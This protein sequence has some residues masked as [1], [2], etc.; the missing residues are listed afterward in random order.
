MA[1]TKMKMKKD[2]AKQVEAKGDLAGMAF[3][4]L[5]SILVLLQGGFYAEPSCIAGIAIVVM[6]IIVYVIQ[7]RRCIVLHVP[8]SAY[9]FLGIA[10]SALIGSSIAGLNAGFV[11]ETSPWFFAAAAATLSAFIR[12]EARESA[13]NMLGWVGVASA[14]V[15]IIMYA[16]LLPLE[17]SENMGRLQF[18]FQYANAAGIWFAIVSIVAMTSTEKR[19]R[20][21]GFFPLAALLFTQSVGAVSIFVIAIVLVLIRWGKEGSA[22]R[23]WALLMQLLCAFAACAIQIV[24]ITDLMFSPLSVLAGFGVLLLLRRLVG[25]ALEERPVSSGV[26]LA[27]SL[28]ILAIAVIACVGALAYTGRLLQ[29]SQTFIE[30]L[31]QTQDAIELLKEG[32]LFGTG[33]GSWS[34]LYQGVQSVQYTASVVHNS[35]AQ[36]ALDSGIVGL[37]LFLAIVIEGFILLRKKHD[38]RAM[39]LAVMMLLHFL[40]DFDLQ[41]TSLIMLFVLFIVPSREEEDQSSFTDRLS[42]LSL[43]AISVLCALGCAAGLWAQMQKNELFAQA[44]AGDLQLVEQ[45]LESDN[46]L[47][48]DPEMKELYLQCL[49]GQGEYSKAA[50]IYSSWDHTSANEATSVAYALYQADSPLEAEEILVE[51]LFQQPKNVDFFN[52]VVEIFAMQGTSSEAVERYAA[53]ATVA[54]QPAQGLGSLMTNQ[55]KVP[56]TLDEAID[57]ETP[58]AE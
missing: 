28:G 9:L 50:R 26:L 19:L 52:D 55:K 10:V 13:L 3:I 1:K 12:T 33:P 20:I 39:L 6:A 44:Q 36:I 30:R 51:K 21:A 14:C 29:A 16:G 17:G 48:Q 57:E 58:I 11:I 41:F 46:F 47:A 43:I 53:A 23:I 31:L 22:A 18:T 2:D 5:L 49:I 8:L 27:I 34:S 35:Y 15:A 25:P 56:V 37:A 40:I 7:Y 45:R 32:L 24:A 38:W 54:N 4:V 42:I